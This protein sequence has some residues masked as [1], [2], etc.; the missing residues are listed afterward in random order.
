MKTCT[1]CR[2]PYHDNNGVE[3]C[4]I[5][6]LKTALEA[7]VENHAVKGCRNFEPSA[8]VVP[9]IVAQRWDEELTRNRI[10]G[11]R[12]LAQM[13]A[14][15]AIQAERA[16]PHSPLADLM[17]AKAKEAHQNMLKLNPEPC[18]GNA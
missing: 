13:C 11:W 14:G 3:R 6:S 7:S 18:H 12:T 5:S 8:V 17:A 15:I 16:R 1:A 10:A 4:R 9:Q 2:L